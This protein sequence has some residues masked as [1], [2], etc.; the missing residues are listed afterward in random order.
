MIEIMMCPSLVFADVPAWLGH[1]VVVDAHNAHKTAVEAK[2]LFVDYNV[3]RRDASRKV[4]G[5]HAIL[6]KLG[7]DAALRVGCQVTAQR[8]ERVDPAVDVVVG[9]IAAL[10]H[11]V[12]DHVVP[13]LL[14]DLALARQ[15]YPDI[16]YKRYGKRVVCYIG[17]QPG[18]KQDTWTRAFD[19]IEATASSNKPTRLF[20]DF[21]DCCSLHHHYTQLEKRAFAFNWYDDYDEWSE[22]LM[23]KLFA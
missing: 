15:H 9:T 18:V 21:E 17:S 13:E 8:E 20:I 3:D 23:S 7:V 6:V 19:H 10:P 22:E 1:Q 2:L 14:V 5:I 4:A 16:G 11:L 12:V